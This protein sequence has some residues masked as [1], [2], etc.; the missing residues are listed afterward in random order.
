MATIDSDAH[1]VESEHTWDFMEKSEQ[2]Y[3]PILAV[4]K[5]DPKRGY[6][7]VEG[8]IRGLPPRLAM[9]LEQFQ[10]ESRKLGRNVTALPKA[11]TGEDEDNLIICQL[12]SALSKGKAR[13]IARVNNPKNAS[14]FRRL[15]PYILTR[16]IVA[17][18]FDN[19][20]VIVAEHIPVAHHTGPSVKLVDALLVIL[21]QR[22]IWF[23]FHPESHEV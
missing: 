4:D 13:T 21:H 18:A 3:R 9:S 15:G 1:V 19:G 8:Q 2:R 17:M 23:P 16:D 14:V 7:V 22:F 6:W 5:N 11:V 10:E 20:V 12:A